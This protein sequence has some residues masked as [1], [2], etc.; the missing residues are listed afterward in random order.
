MQIRRLSVQGIAEAVEELALVRAGETE[1]LSRALLESDEFSESIGLRVSAPRE[2]TT[3]WQLGIWLYQHLDGRIDERTVADPGFWSWMAVWLFDLIC[4]VREGQRKVR[5]DARYILRSGDFRK[6]YRHLVAG[7]YLLYRA[8]ADAPNVLR[9]LLATAP[10]A[11]GEIYEQLASRKYLITSRA[12]VETVQRLYYDA[13][14]ATVRRGAAG[15]GAGSARR[16]GEILQQFDK[17]YD[18][19]S[20]GANR[21]IELL[22]REFDRFRR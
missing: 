12:V 19:N 8:H 21:L 17:T 5:D 22:P 13:Q 2:I 14:A 9:V 6:S 3:R 16:F 18:L 10:D 4:P 15:A 20:I 7:P 11:P 1:S